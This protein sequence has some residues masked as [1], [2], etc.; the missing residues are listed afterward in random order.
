MKRVLLLSLVL[1]GCAS[2]PQVKQPMPDEAYTHLPLMLVAAQKCAEQGMISPAL[3][4]FGNIHLRQQAGMWD[5]DMQRWNA[6]INHV[7]SIGAPEQSHCN[8]L[9]MTLEGYK[10]QAQEQKELAQAQREDIKALKDQMNKP[11]GRTFCTN[12]GGYVL[13][14][15]Y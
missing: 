9:A 13:C 1:A 7:Q 8:S 10:Q 6:R 14:N 11:A 12:T 3:A 4:A 2:T 5:V 15:S